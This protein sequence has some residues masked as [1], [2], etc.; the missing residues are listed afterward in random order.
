MMRDE[1]AMLSL[2]DRFKE[3]ALLGS[4]SSLLSWDEQTYMPRGG[5]EARGEQLALLAGLVHD[6]STDPQVGVWLDLAGTPDDPESA[7]AVN[8]R[9]WRRRYERARKLPRALVEELS[10]AQ[11]KAQQSW[12]DARRT[13]DFKVLEPDLARVVGLKRDQAACWAGAG[14]TGSSLYDALMDEYE[15]GLSAER[16]RPIFATL[17]ARIS[18]LLDTIRGRAKV[19]GEDARAV[20]KK[21]Y[22]LDRQAYFAELVSGS[23]GFDLGR[24]RIDL[25]EHPFCSG[26]GPGDCRLT[27]RYRLDDFETGLFAVLHETGHGLYEQGLDV[28]A[29]GTPMGEAAGLGVHESQSRFWEN[30]VGRSRAF[31]SYWYPLAQRTFP[32]ALGGVSPDTFH[33][34]IHH[35]E[36]SLIR[37]EADE[38]TYNLHIAIRFALEH[39]L[40]GGNLTVAELPA[41]WNAVYEQKLGV[42]PKNDAEGVMQDIHWPIGLIG[43]F[44]TY[45]IGNLLAAQLMA[46]IRREN[47]AVDE[48][49]GR[50]QT[51]PILDWL[52]NRVH[53]QGQRYHLDE[54]AV[55]A[56]GRPLSADDLSADL[57]RRFGDS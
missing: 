1:K 32:A 38:V 28:S 41:A 29:Y 14:A 31:W 55:H 12:L 56:T 16:L 24:G 27:A 44:P 40:I 35:V 34:A 23:I 2:K 19:A 42:R 57:T 21:E 53:R 37:I 45:T 39:E 26:I 11:T 10:R 30:L 22:P 52:R 43:Y 5:A 33:R 36:P 18:E 25:T 15:P 3:V 48:A 9:E 6:K 7:E 20:L 49:L 4:C 47:A 54:L 50:G 46:A 13:R 8:L 17:E 51:G